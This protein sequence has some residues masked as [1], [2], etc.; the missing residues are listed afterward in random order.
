MPAFQL[1]KPI[2]VIS[3]HFRP[4]I[5]ELFNFN[6]LRL[7]TKRVQAKWSILLMSVLSTGF[8]V[9]IRQL[10]WLQFLELTSFDYLVAA[11][12]NTEAPDSRLLIVGI[13]EADIQNLGHWPISDQVLA[14]VL[15]TLQLH[16]PKVIGIDI[17]RDIPQEPG[18]MALVNQLQA[19]NVIAIETIGAVPAPASIDESRVGFN[20]LV[21]DPDGI[22]RRNLLF[23]KVG[24]QAYYSFALRLS[25]AYLGDQAQPVQADAVLT[26]GETR[27]PRLRQTSGGYQS[28]DSA[29]YQSLLR[30]RKANSVAR[31]VTLTEILQGDFQPEW[32]NNKVIL[33]GSIA[34][35][36]KD[37]FFTPNTR[38]NQGEAVTS[39]V[40]IHAHLVSQILSTVLAEQSLFWFYADWAEVLLIWALT[41][42]GT[43]LAWRRKHPLILVLI[44][45]VITLSIIG[46]G[47]GGLLLAVWLPIVAPFLGFITSFAL[48]ISYKRLY[49][50]RM[51][52]TF[53][54]SNQKL[55][56]YSEHLKHY[57]QAL[58]E[59]NLQLNQALEELKQTQAQLIQ[60]E[61]MSGLGQMVA[62]VAHEINN[63]MCFIEG[64]LPH[65]E[66]YTQDLID[67]I[68]LYQKHYP[69]PDS[70]ILDKVQEIDLDYLLE[71]LPKT[72][73]SMQIGSE[74]VSEI[75]SSLRN[76]SR[77]DESDIK[78]ANITE[79]IDNTLMILM[80]R[81]KEQ[82]KRPEI[83][84]VKDYSCN[85]EVEC[86]PG[87]LNQ[88]FMNILNNSIDAFDQYSQA[89]ASS[90]EQLETWQPQI[91]IRT[92]Q[93]QQTFIVTI[94]DN[95]PGM[96]ESVR[97]QIFNAFFTT[98]PVG[99]GTGLGL[100]ISYKIMVDKH[101]GEI[102]CESK[103]GQGTTFKLHIPTS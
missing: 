55:E 11:Q 43:T 53:K 29:G 70:E 65:V 41:L 100:S 76:F 80:N 35:S 60:S 54:V 85:S 4:V 94:A 28:I 66:D 40:T 23:A 75:V 101:G 59:K 82:P 42:V 27:F 98:K 51:A 6:P 102:F 86:C 17:Y 67:L 3:K 14:D 18:H 84:I 22:V 71:D 83:N 7:S 79:G 56:T 33:I 15:A 64:N 78:V 90:P 5:Q 16:Q 69:N 26:L 46:I 34:P 91:C 44:G 89:L 36:A 96:P 97:R 25:L 61:K 2:T 31:Q 21:I 52:Q 73:S 19:S 74:R 95:G 93:Q 49:D 72:L 48:C 62:G 30:Y 92:E 39:G 68:E 57:S 20:D 47:Y 63:P 9:G 45:I 88:V 13:S 77:L 50:S 103:V 32:I 8:V 81:L 37:N 24:D 87:Q 10:G 1:H 12:P 38:F 99:Q 58:E